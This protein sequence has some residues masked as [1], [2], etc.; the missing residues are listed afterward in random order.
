MK[1]R[2]IL[3]LVPIVLIIIIVAAAFG[4]K[5]WDRF[6]YSREHADLNEYFGLTE[7]SDCAIV[8]QTKL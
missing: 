3:V 7:D 5:I 4:G 6:S 2:I 1:K 8:L